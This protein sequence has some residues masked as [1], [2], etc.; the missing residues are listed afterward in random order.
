[1]AD[2]TS[3]CPK[4]WLTDRV[5]KVTSVYASG[6]STG[7]TDIKGD[8]RSL[9]NQ[10]LK[11]PPRPRKPR[12]PGV[13][14]GLAVAALLIGGISLTIGLWDKSSEFGTPDYGTVAAMGRAF[15]VAGVF[16]L[17][18]WAVIVVFIIVAYRG[19]R[20]RFSRQ[21]TQWER[22]MEV[23]SR[24]CY[25]SRDNGVFLPGQSEF[26]P[27]EKLHVFLSRPAGQTATTQAHLRRR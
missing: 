27:P 21:F 25:C 11:P 1:M 17:A 7:R 14:V 3:R 15:T 18:V 23:W 12:A 24:L 26:L 5:Q 6:P 19:S 10:T 13:L 20:R 9:L 2:Q 16:A 8:S 22:R 4:C